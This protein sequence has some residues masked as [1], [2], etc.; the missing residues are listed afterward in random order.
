MFRRLHRGWTITREV[1]HPGNY[2]AKRGDE[3]LRWRFDWG[4]A[5]VMADLDRL[6]EAEE[7]AE[8]ERERAEAARLRRLAEEAERERLWLSRLPSTSC[9]RCGAPQVEAQV[10]GGRR[11]PLNVLP[12]PGGD[13]V[14]YACRIDGRV[15]MVRRA[16]PGE[17]NADRY[18]VHATTCTGRP[19]LAD[20]DGQYRLRLGKYAAPHD[21]PK[22]RRRKPRQLRLPSAVQIE[23]PV[24]LGANQGQ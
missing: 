21:V 2:V 15:P 23:F 10:D 17:Q 18:E 4:V 12:D 19:P 14:A 22:R 20:R 6:A 11:I 8:R 24:P 9:R 16:E 7:Q 5:G 3:V 1:H 13:W